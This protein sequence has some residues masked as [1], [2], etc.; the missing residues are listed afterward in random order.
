[1]TKTL[2]ALLRCVPAPRARQRRRNQSCTPPRGMIRS[3][4]ALPNFRVGLGAFDRVGCEA[5]ALYN[6]LRLRG[7]PPPLWEII[8]SLAGCRC[9]MLLGLAGA[10]PF[11]LGP[12]LQSRG[13]AVERFAGRRDYPAFRAAAEEGGLFLVSYW[14]APWRLH[15]V[16]FTVS[17]GAWRLW[18][19]G[20]A[21]WGPGL[22]A[23]SPRMARLF[24][25]GYRILP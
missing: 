10:D 1:M 8:D 16:A 7:C 6:A 13:M 14:T 5:A 21:E 19:A 23:I 9:L 24:I 20:A 4:R 12:W 3:Q 2:F 11:T 17:D 25:A 18:N 22:E 15:T